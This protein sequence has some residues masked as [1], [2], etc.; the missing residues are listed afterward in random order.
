MHRVV[1][2]TRVAD[3]QDI[4][5]LRKYIGYLSHE[6]INNKTLITLLANYNWVNGKKLL[7]G[8][9]NLNLASFNTRDN[10]VAVKDRFEKGVRF[11]TNISDLG[12]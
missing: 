11:Y 7:M 5:E 10:L 1:I 6:V 8:S 9:A 4:I 3:Y 12:K 2:E